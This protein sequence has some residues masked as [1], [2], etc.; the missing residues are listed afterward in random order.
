MGAAEIEPEKDGMR[1]NDL[2]TTI[3]HAGSKTPG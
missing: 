1:I 2:E 3:R